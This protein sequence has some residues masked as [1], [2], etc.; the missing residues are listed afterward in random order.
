MKPNNELIYL[1]RALSAIYSAE[2][3]DVIDSSR[4]KVRIYLI[5]N[6]S[7]SFLRFRNENILEVLKSGPGHFEFL[8]LTIRYFRNIS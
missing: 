7:F 6:A 1:C 3:D 8:C 2:S 4:V 5:S